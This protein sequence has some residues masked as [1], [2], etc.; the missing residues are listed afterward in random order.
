VKTLTT[1]CRPLLFAGCLLWIGPPL[2]R[3]RAQATAPPIASN[4]VELA[5]QLRRGHVMVPAR[6]NDA[7]PYLFMLD[8]GYGTT[9][10]GQELVESL[11][12]RRTGRMTIVGIAGE[13]EAGVFDGPTFDFAGASWTPRRVAAFPASDSGRGRRR[14]GIL[15]SGFFRRFVVEIDP[16]AKFV[17]LHDPSGF[18]YRGT[19]EILPLTFKSSTPVVEAA[20]GLAGQAS[21]KAQF[22]I[23]TGCTGG[24]CLGSHFVAAH[25]LAPTNGPADGGRYGVG[26]GTRTR[27]GHLHQLMLGKI[28]LE[29]PAA[30]F[31]LNGSPVEA[32]LAGHI[33]W[34]L[35]REFR[36]I[37]DYQRKRMILEPKP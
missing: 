31:F 36:V 1:I 24:L 21:I 14:D 9:L 6:V 27:S 8:T 11:G 7:G 12:L 16:A 15:G 3:I 37:F 23:D 19:G 10:L 33:G 17:R 5:Y 20:V 30:D 22:E 25:R 2:P 29:K 13:E 35:L 18:Q 32:P 4:S 34:D 26:G 28:R